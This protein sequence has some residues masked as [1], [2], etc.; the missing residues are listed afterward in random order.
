M[1]HFV[2]WLVQLAMLNSCSS[3]PHRQVRNSRKGWCSIHQ[4]R[5]TRDQIRHEPAQHFLQAS[6]SRKGPGDWRVSNSS[7]SQMIL[8]TSVSHRLIYSI[9]HIAVQ[10]PMA[11]SRSSANAPS[12]ATSKFSPAKPLKPLIAP[13]FPKHSFPTC[14]KSL[15][16]RPSSTKKQALNSSKVKLL[17]STSP[18]R[19]SALLAARATTTPSW[20]LRSVDTRRVCHFQA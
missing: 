12:R 1:L 14:R 6:R 19:Q 17:L 7:N 15:G 3:R 9:L 20:L 16:A 5:R 10:A 2:L 18:P 4:G 13:S 8:D 11:S